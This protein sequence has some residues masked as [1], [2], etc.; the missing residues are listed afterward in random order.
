MNYY[1]Q[2]FNGIFWIPDRYKKKVIATL[3]IDENGSATI[4]SL[5]PLEDET[6][7]TDKWGETKLVLGYLN[8]HSDSKTYSV[9]LYDT[10]KSYQSIGPLDKIK[11][12]SDNILIAS[13]YDS[14]IESNLYNILMLSSDEL[15]NWIPISGFDFNTKIDKKFE[16]SHLYNQP[17]IIK[18]FKNK[19]F[20]VYL[21]FRASTNFQRRRK[22]HIIETV[23]I[24]IEPNAPF[25]ITEL[26]KIRKSIERL[27]SLILFKP[28]LSKVIELRTKGRATYKAIKKSNKPD[29]GLGKEIEFEIFTKYSNSIFEKWYEKQKTLELAIINFFS[30]YGQKGVLIENKFLTY[31][32]ILEN[33]HKNHINKNGYLK[34]RLEYLLN[35][36]SLASQLKKLD[37][38]AERLKITRNY[39]AHLEEK[40]KAKSLKSEEILKTNYLLEFIIREIFL[41][42]I[43]INHN[44]IIPHNVERY[45]IELNN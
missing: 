10:Y 5:Q 32:S 29:Y 21:Y 13:A 41:R 15:N 17:D 38:Y 33:Y 23:F 44:S 18:L 31:I 14:E 40:H 36:S 7:I 24:N 43:G 34:T 4:S 6:D 20:S 3:F 9:K 2:Y 16:I 39:H 26:S 8:C 25:E 37:E 27:F 45:I 12:K 1:N 19:D 35:N 11:Y 28:F 30:V 42:E 22:S